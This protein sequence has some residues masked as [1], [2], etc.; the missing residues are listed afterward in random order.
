MISILTCCQLMPNFSSC[1]LSVLLAFALHLRLTYLNGVTGFSE[2]DKS[3]FLGLFLAEPNAPFL[4]L[5]GLYILM[6]Q[7][8]LDKY[9][10]SSDK[11]KKLGQFCMLYFPCHV[12]QIVLFSC[13][14]SKHTC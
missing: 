3:R 1:L 10:I 14:S 4:G 9:V 8:C 5:D 2:G 7:N 11:P 13:T 6:K 12:N